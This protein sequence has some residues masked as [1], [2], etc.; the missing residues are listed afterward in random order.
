M[1]YDLGKIRQK[2]LNKLGTQIYINMFVYGMKMK[3]T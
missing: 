1:K 2:L 3:F